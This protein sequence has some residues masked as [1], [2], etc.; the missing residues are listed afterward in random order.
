M[1]AIRSPWSVRPIHEMDLCFLLISSKKAE[2]ATTLFANKHS[3][4]RRMA[5][6]AIVLSGELLS[7]CSKLQELINAEEREEEKS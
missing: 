7:L 3:S 5:K 1:S 4:Q 6:K 2:I